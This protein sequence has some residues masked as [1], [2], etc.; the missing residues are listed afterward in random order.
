M[1]SV[2]A[3]FFQPVCFSSEETDK[4]ICVKH[5]C[6]FV[7]IKLHVQGLLLGLAYLNAG[8]LARSQYGT[9]TICDRPTRSTCFV[10][11][12]SPTLI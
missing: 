3:L 10:V 7:K 12:R 1:S 9:A 2:F 4:K 8:L 11:Y 6:A 5:T